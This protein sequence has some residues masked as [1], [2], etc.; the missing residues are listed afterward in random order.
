MTTLSA[1]RPYLFYCPLIHS[2]IVYFPLIYHLMI[3]VDSKVVLPFLCFLS[4]VPPTKKQFWC[5]LIQK[6]NSHAYIMK[7][8]WYYHRPFKYI[9]HIFIMIVS[10]SEI[11]ENQVHVNEIRYVINVNYSTCKFG[12]IKE[13][14]NNITNCIILQSEKYFS[15]RY[16]QK[17]ICIWRNINFWK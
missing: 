6:K 8:G 16:F 9:K 15:Y 4:L 11:S 2:V 7:L 10:I 5:A 14:W 12:E 3:S 17:K 13:T 1:P